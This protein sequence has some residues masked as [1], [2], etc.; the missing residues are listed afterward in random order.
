M[1]SRI[2][3][4]YMWAL[5]AFAIVSC[6]SSPPSIPVV[7][8][9]KYLSNPQQGLVTVEAI[10]YGK[11][12]KV[13]IEDAYQVAFNTI[14]FKGLPGITSLENP[15]INNE[16]KARSANSVYFKQFFERQGYL[17]FVTQQ[18][19]SE[20]VEKGNNKKSKMVIQIF[21]IDYNLLRKDLE[22]NKVL[23]KFGL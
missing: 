6:K 19:T 15:M 11:N 4:S 9:V 12:E 16:M 3:Y 17:R 21:T 13:A 22:Q 14:L 23:R 20:F 2:A 1:M 5:F 8:E 7:S 18:D 10:G